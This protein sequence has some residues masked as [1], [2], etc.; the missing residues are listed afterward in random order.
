MQTTRILFI[1]AGRM[2]QAIVHGL[3]Q[4][5]DEPVWDITVTNRANSK[6]LTALKE[7]YGVRTVTDWSGEVTKSDVIV[8]AM[9]P[10]DHAEVLTVLHGLVETQLVV[11]V[12]AGIGVSGLAQALKPETSVAWVMPNTAA[13]IGES[14]TL[15]AC[16]QHVTG[17]QHATLTALLSGLGRYQACSEA[18]IRGLTAITGSA[19][20]FVFRMAQV[21]EQMA[22]TYGIE[23]KAARMM[24]GQM[25][26]GSAKLILA[27]GQPLALA[28]EVTT[29]GGVTAAGIAVLEEGR[30]DD[31]IHRAVLAANERADQLRVSQDP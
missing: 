4:Q 2:A 24:V 20:A 29:P 26:L 7:R 15:Y 5:N 21:L 6:R 31:L 18:Q 11:S 14:M 22:M 19:S 13:G 28:D 1:G 3:V 16:G 17:A 12:A 23:E 8:L 30:M 27:G 10:E 9:P 25:M